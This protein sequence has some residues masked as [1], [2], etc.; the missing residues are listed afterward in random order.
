MP[1]TYSPLPTPYPSS[2]A[3]ASASSPAASTPNYSRGGLTFSRRFSKAGL[4]P[5]DEVQWE[6]RTA[7]ITDAS[8]KSIFEQ[9]DVEVPVD[10]SMTATN[11]VASKYLHGQ[12][13]TPER[14][15]GVRQLVGRVA[16]TI[17]DW[18]IASGY[19]SSTQDAAIFHDELVAML[20]SQ[21]VAFNSP[22]WFNVG[23]DRLEPNSD[24]QN[25]HWDPHTCAVRFSVTGYRNPQ[26]SACFINAVDDSLDAILTLAKT[27]GMLFKWGSGTGTNLSSIRGSM[28]L[29]S[30]G[31]TASGPLSFMRGFDAFA[32]VIKSG[33]KTRRAAKM[34]ILNVDHPDIVDFIDCKSREEAKA[35]ALIRA[36][37]D[38]SG[39]DSEAYSSIFFQNAN[40]SV[41]VNDEFMRAYERDGEF[42]TLTVKDRQPVKTY[43]ARDIMTKIAEATWQCGDPGMQFDTTI[44]RW[45]TAPN[46]GRINGSNPCFP[47]S[48][49]VHTDKGMIRFSE[50]F[51]RANRGVHDGI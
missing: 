38:G 31:G 41:R 30:G 18:G 22:V 7:S 25:W 34:V 42:T 17:R 44:N 4:S 23:C 51:D 10:W 37:Y 47:G 1:D 50:L 36:G 5:Y 8:G 3:T 28:E 15:T 6:R 35:Y 24:A 12:I 21:K 19:F 46:A 2:G 27:E 33:G 29:L 26:C 11:I 20:V 32:G 43:K 40:N 9:K 48:A 16:E 49:L 14:E 39:P 13:G 45:H